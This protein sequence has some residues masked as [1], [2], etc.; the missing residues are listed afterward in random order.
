ML[1]ALSSRDPIPR[2]IVRYNDSPLSKFFSVYSLDKALLTQLSQVVL[3]CGFG[4]IGPVVGHISEEYFPSE[5]QTCIYEKGENTL[6][7]TLFSHVSPAGSDRENTAEIYSPGRLWIKWVDFGHMYPVQGKL[8]VPSPSKHLLRGASQAKSASE[9]APHGDQPV[10]R[11]PRNR[12]HKNALHGLKTAALTVRR[13]LSHANAPNP[14][15]NW[16]AGVRVTASNSSQT[17]LGE[18]HLRPDQDH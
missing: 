8:Y 10:R 16:R 12:M 9:K 6:F 11:T 14:T 2:V 1:N 15:K 4:E 18:G 13:D 7:A 3:D 17:T 5:G